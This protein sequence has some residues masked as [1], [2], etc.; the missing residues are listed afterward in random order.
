MRT[1]EE[2][3][4]AGVAGLSIEDTEL[5][6]PYGSGATGLI[7]LGEGL[8]KIRAALA[9]RQDPGTVI[10]ARTGAPSVTGMTDALVR[11]RAYDASG[12]DV[13]FFTGV[14][15]REQLEALAAATSLPIMLGGL[16]DTLQD[17]A[18]LASQRVRIALQGHQPFAAGT[19]AVYATLKQ[20]REGV[21]PS[22]LTGLPD[23]SFM[24]RL[25]REA[26]YIRHTREFLGGA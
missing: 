9:A 14:A 1:V 6:R 22:E 26:E 13:L 23:A 8:G 4:N 21:A 2:L 17:R 15:D 12:A 25:S 16:P 7:P 19:A 18:Y 20:L 24:K 5:P 10:M 11:A 3:E